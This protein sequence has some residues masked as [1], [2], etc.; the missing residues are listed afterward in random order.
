M[1]KI[2]FAGVYLF[3]VSCCDVREV[4]VKSDIKYGEAVNDKDIL[5]PLL[6]DMYYTGEL[7]GKKRPAIIFVHGGGFRT[8]DKQ[9]AM[10]I[11]MCRAFAEA[12]YIS[13]SVNYRVSTHGKITLPVLNNTLNDVLLA[14]RWILEH[15]DEYGVDP[16]KMLIAGDSAGG[17]IVV[18]MAY[19]NEGRELI[20]GCIDLWGGLPFSHSEPDVDRYG[21]PVNYNPIPSGVPPTC[22]FHSKGDDIIPVATS[23]NLANELKEKGIVHEIHLLNSADHYPENMADQFIPVMIAFANKIAD[24]Y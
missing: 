7:S 21:Q 16:A 23:I 17:G 24:N 12:G 4:N 1:K 3:S 15:S 22:I 14:F 10:Y 6:M 19:S 11:K 2:I 8:G 20:A 13:F 5:Q 18:N 9:Q